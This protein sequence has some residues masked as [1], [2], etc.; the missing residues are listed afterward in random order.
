[1]PRCS[2]PPHGYLKVF[3]ICAFLFLSLITG[4]FWGYT[5]DA[6]SPLIDQGVGLHSGLLGATRYVHDP[7]I[8]KSGGIYY[9]FSTGIGIPVR[10]SA[11]LRTWRKAQPGKV[12]Q[13]MPDFAHAIVPNQ[14]DIWAPDISYFNGRYH[15]YYSVSTFGSNRS[16][17]GLTTN[18]TL[19]AENEAF[20]WS[21]EGIVIEST[22]N[23]N[24]N[25][26]D[27]N[28]I[29]DTSGTPWLAF[30]SFWSGIK[31]RRLD[32]NTG[33]LALG[34]SKTYALAQRFVNNGA[35]EGAYIF[36]K[37]DN[38]YLFTSFD[39]CCQGR[40]STYNVRV[41][42]SK[43]ITGPYIDRDGVAMLKGGG[44]QVTFYSERWRG[45]GHNSLIEDGG[46]DYLVYHAYDAQN[47]GIPTLQI[48]RLNWGDNGWPWTDP[49]W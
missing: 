16:V 25:C 21:D 31:L 34:D 11:D 6:P 18:S 46:V 12:F 10:Q 24:Y 39:S 35:I 38:Y 27:P 48:D 1:M 19:D 45:P 26:I 3:A 2:K 5:F 7:A 41:G 28:L 30:G 29:L 14:F 40:D 43:V 44:T 47:A 8:I 37:G 4:S 13:K 15:L 20:N 23:N 36:H 33:K 9:V 42:R 17:I 32:Y 49:K 22:S